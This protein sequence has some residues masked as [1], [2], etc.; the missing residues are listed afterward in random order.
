LKHADILFK[1]KAR[2]YGIRRCA[3]SEN[4]DLDL[5]DRVLDAARD[6]V[7]SVVGV[8]LPESAVDESDIDDLEATVGPAWRGAAGH[9]GFEKAHHSWG[10][11]P[12]T[13]CTSG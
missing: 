10:G 5:V 2:R 4:L 9:R 11:R 6:G 8:M 3:P 7:D 1:L 13:G 12:A